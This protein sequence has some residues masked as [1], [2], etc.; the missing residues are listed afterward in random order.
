VVVDGFAGTVMV[1]E[2]AHVGA[3]LDEIGAIE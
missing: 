3:E 2:E 1:L